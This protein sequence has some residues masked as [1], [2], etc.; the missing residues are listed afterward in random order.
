MKKENSA[1][2][3]SN[4]THWSTPKD[5]YNA[6]MIKGYLDPCPLHCTYNSLSI[7]YYG[8]K[9]F[10]NPPFEDLYKWTDW[11]I[12][13]VENGC[14]ITLLM[15]ARTDTIYFH[16]LLQYKPSIYFFKGR[17]KFGNSNACAPFPT[18]LVTISKQI[19][20]QLYSSGTVEDFIHGNL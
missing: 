16:K 6:F 18:I 1:C 10:I 9:L 15:P 4:S 11:I 19:R 5:L 14:L 7:D 3:S 17:L 2:F 20:T 8:K 13:Q 12:K